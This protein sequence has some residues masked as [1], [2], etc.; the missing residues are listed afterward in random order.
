MYSVCADVLTVLTFEAAASHNRRAINGFSA[1]SCAVLSVPKPVLSFSGLASYRA[2]G[3]VHAL[4][5]IVGC[6]FLV[7][8]LLHRVSE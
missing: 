6:K 2:L 4:L 1:L 8:D 7:L 5:E 3:H